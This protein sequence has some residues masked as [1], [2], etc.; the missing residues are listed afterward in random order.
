[1]ADFATEL[2]PGAMGESAK[3]IFPAT[4]AG[5]V[6]PLSVDD[7][8]T[9]GGGQKMMEFQEYCMAAKIEKELYLCRKNC[10]EVCRRARDLLKHK[11]RP[12]NPNTELKRQPLQMQSTFSADICTSQFAR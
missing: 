5:L 8:H 4:E 10:D 9:S 6:D 11:R 7:F 3:V 12:E 2:Q 1:M